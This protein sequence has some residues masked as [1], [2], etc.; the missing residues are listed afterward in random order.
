MS[1]RAVHEQKAAERKDDVKRM[2]TEAE[3]ILESDDPDY[4][5]LTGLFDHM[6]GACRSGFRHAYELAFKPHEAEEVQA[7]KETPA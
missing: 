3:A 2:I 1:E 4:R 7:T 6:E 5:R